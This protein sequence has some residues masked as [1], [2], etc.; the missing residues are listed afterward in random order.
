MALGGTRGFGRAQRC[1]DRDG[2]LARVEP[3]G[4]NPIT[5]SFE[6]IG[7]QGQ[8][9]PFFVR[10]EAGPVHGHARQPEPT[11]RVEHRGHFA[12]SFFRM[13]QRRDDEVTGTECGVLLRQGGEGLTGT[14]L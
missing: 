3:A 8:S 11:K 10:M 13:I 2:V 14:D 1:A 6:R 4:F 9:V 12:R 7:R 5:F